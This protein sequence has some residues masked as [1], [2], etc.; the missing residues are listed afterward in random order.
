M[1]LPSIL[2]KSFYKCLIAFANTY[3]VYRE[4]HKTRRIECWMRSTYDD[5]KVREDSSN[6]IQ[7]L[8]H[9]HCI[10]THK[11]YA[12]HIGLKRPDGFNIVFSQKCQA[13]DMPS[14]LQACGKLHKPERITLKA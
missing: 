6:L 9:H 3:S 11:A 4:N 13:N 2:F 1:P 5:E 8:M 14:L 12:K 7:D 10:R